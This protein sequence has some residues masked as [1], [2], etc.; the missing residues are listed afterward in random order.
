MR[1]NLTIMAS[2]V[3]HDSHM[4]HVSFHRI[5]DSGMRDSLAVHVVFA[6]VMFFKVSMIAMRCSGFVLSAD[7]AGAFCKVNIA[8]QR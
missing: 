8:M 5:Y 2:R 3:L 7:Y 4:H 1:C 6:F